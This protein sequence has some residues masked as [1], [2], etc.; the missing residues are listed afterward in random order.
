MFLYVCE[1]FRFGKRKGH[2][3]QPAAPFV[4]VED[5]GQFAVGADRFGGFLNAFGRR[6]VLEGHQVVAL[7]G[8][9]DQEYARITEHCVRP[10]FSS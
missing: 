6:H 5:A 8:Q 10:Q 4:A 3:F 1:A 7:V 9:L 2:I